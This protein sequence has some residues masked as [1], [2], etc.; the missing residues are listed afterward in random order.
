M[1]PMKIVDL[2]VLQECYSKLLQVYVNQ[3]E[4]QV[5]HLF[6]IRQNIVKMEKYTYNN[7]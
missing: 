6:Q 4:N 1:Y 3:H 7:S 5:D 2:R